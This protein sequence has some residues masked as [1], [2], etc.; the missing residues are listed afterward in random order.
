MSLGYKCLGLDGQYHLVVEKDGR[1]WREVPEPNYDFI[2]ERAD[3]GKKLTYKL[4]YQSSRK[5]PAMM[6]HSNSVIV[7][8][9][10]FF[11]THDSRAL[12]NDYIR[13]RVWYGTDGVYNTPEG[14]FLLV[15]SDGFLMDTAFHIK[16][17]PDGVGNEFEDGDK[18]FSRVK[19]DASD[20]TL[21]N[22][23]DYLIRVTDKARMIMKRVRIKFTVTYPETSQQFESSIVLGRKDE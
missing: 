19:R 9:A 21:P 7:K 3:V 4:F 13:F 8:D 17:Y 11:V 6:I 12:Y 1:Y 18:F 23:D 5:G 22:T 10:P 20:T 14:P 15:K 2:P 16:Q